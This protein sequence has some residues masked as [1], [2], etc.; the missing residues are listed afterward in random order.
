AQ[1]THR[2]FEVFRSGR[3][4]G[5]DYAYGAICKPQDSRSG[6]FAL[7]I[8]QAGHSYSAHTL[9]IAHEPSEHVDV[10]TRLVHEDATVISPRA[11]PISR[12]VVSLIPLPPQPYRPHHQ[13][14][15][16][17]LFEGLASLDYG[18]VVPILVHHKDLD[19]MCVTGPNYAIR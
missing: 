2:S 18:R 4:R 12:I 5:L 6:I 16:T 1:Y 10:M 11:T 13:L 14:A 9:H 8:N 7:D 3:R 15:E 17:A 19:T